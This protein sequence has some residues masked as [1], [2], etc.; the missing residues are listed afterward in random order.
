[1]IL[2]GYELLLFTMIYL[3]SSRGVLR[4]WAIGQPYTSRKE[5]AQNIISAQQA[6]F[7]EFELKSSEPRRQKTALQQI[8]Q[9]Y[10]NGIRFSPQT[11]NLFEMM[12][13][14]LAVNSH[15][16]KVVRWSL[17]SIARLG[18]QS[19]TTRSVEDAVKRHQENPEIVAAAVSA[20][21]H[22]Y[23]GQIPE[24][25]GLKEVSLE[26]R[27]LAAMQT[28][29][30]EVLELRGL[31]IN[32]GQ[33]DPE[34]LKL[35]LIVVGLNKDIQNLLHPRHEN[36][37]V[38]RDLG[39]HDDPIVR[40]YSVWAVIENNNLSLKHLGIRF[41]DIERQ[42]SNV[43]AKMLHLGATSIENLHERQSLIVQGSGFYI[44]RCAGRSVQRSSF[45]L[46]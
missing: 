1:M 24:L 46:L 9:L 40:Q 18:R 43:Q 39:Q 38:V 2:T 13:S 41:E 8:C 28:V 37:E 12:I 10:R 23:R 29:S 6:A 25:E 5:L 20:L 16:D 17:N 11:R 22:L 32:I 14:G 42:P 34:I 27:L 33:A 4:Y 3:I 15:D 21:A 31:A 45:G 35:A 7:L 36:G 26:T 30:P 44:D 19:S